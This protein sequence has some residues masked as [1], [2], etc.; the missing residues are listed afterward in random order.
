MYLAWDKESKTKKIWICKF[1]KESKKR[2]DGFANLKKKVK[3]DDMVL[4]I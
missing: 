1:E 4:Q 3:K 2:L